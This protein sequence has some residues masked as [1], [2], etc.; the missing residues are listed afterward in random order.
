[1]IAV[2]EAQIA[3]GDWPQVCEQMPDEDP[4]RLTGYVA[5]LDVLGFRAMV[6]GAESEKKLGQYIETVDGAVR[7]AGSDL[8]QYVIFS[9]S[10]VVNS[11]DDTANS[12]NAIVAS[13]GTL[14]SRFL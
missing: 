1:M 4:Q 3:H 11:K 10:L 13:C 12:F 2:D 5:F 14:F 9:D 6:S 7:D 8:V